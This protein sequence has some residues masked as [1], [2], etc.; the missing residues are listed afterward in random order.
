MAC[1][2][3]LD[4]ESTGLSTK[5]DRIVSIAASCEGEEFHEL[6]NP[7]VRIPFHATRVHGISDAD[8][9]RCRTWKDVGATLAEWIR[10]RKRGRLVQIIAHNARYDTALLRAENRRHGV[11]FPNFSVIDTLLVC[12]AALTKLASHRQ[13]VVYEHLFGEPPPDQHCALGDVRALVRICASD[14]I[15]AILKPS[16]FFQKTSIRTCRACRVVYSVYFE[17]ACRRTTLPSGS[18]L[19]R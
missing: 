16:H 11:D 19:S 13:A 18:P 17:H 2:V 4:S 10:A 5:R 7:G 15:S 8:V 3:Y 6:V 14:R 1:R 9:Q 12:R